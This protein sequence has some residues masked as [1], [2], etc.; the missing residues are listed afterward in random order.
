MTELRLGTCEMVAA[1]LGAQNP[2][3]P[4]H[5]YRTVSI[6]EAAEA[7]S[8]APSYPDR[9]YEDSILP[10]RLQDAYNRVKHA[11]K[12]ATAVLEN[13][14]L[15]ATF[16]LERG[17]RLWSL[18]HKPS[19]RELLHVNPVFQPANLA[20]RDAWFSGGV[21]WNLSIIGHCP[22]T[23]SPLFAANVMAEDG[24][25]VLRLYEYERVRRVPFQIDFHLPAGSEFLFARPRIVNTNAHAVPMYWWSNIAVD[26]SPGVRVLAPANAAYFH[27]Y[28]RRL[29][30]QDLPMRGREDVTYPGR[31]SAAADLY[32][33]IPPQRWPWVAALDAAGRGMVHAST[34]R[35]MGRKMFLWGMGPGGRRWQE[36]LAAPG[37]Q[38]IEIQGGLA[39]T[40]TEYV[41]MPAGACWEWV[42]AFGS[43]DADPKSVHSA[44]WASA[45]EHVD[46]KLES[47]LPRNELEARLQHW[48]AD[49]DRAPVE[50]LQEGS[51]WGALEDRRRRKAGL[52]AMGSAATP[53][54][55]STLG[56]EQEPWRRLLD[57]GAFPYR[58]PSQ[59]PGAYL[60]D[61]AW[62]D[63]LEHAIAAGRGVHWLSLLHAGI[64]RYRA[65]DRAGAREAWERSLAAEP[66]AWAQ[67]NVA[68]ISLDEGNKARA[69]ELLA[70]AARMRPGLTPLAIE[71]CQTMLAAG[72]YSQLRRLIG[73]L[74]DEVATTGRVRLIGTI[75]ALRSGDLEAPA[76]FFS[77]PCD[78]PN[79]RE[80][81]ISLSELW[82]EWHEAR[83]SR[84][85]DVPIDD[86]L[87]RQVRREHPLPRKFDFRM[88][89]D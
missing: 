65:G 41:T 75:A 4:L 38:Y 60:T 59:S 50:I 36:Y 12:F 7:S 22:F 89:A 35:L 26:E 46:A 1:E 80:G 57:E 56:D 34:Q 81:E 49:A 79:I 28:D 27:D 2:L 39:T 76:A 44:D 29:K 43:F 18:F 58:E 66:S 54:A 52:V 8:A 48:H 62:R 21:E 70:V 68:I 63:L 19:Q 32:F 64:M 25:P 53:F 30:S 37:H 3:P 5:A 69:A 11:R 84:Q 33:R 10:Y 85:Q 31:R 72:Q 9:G 16:L 86:A 73:R 74:P 6:T 88:K 47:V 71:A 51:G 82:F 83:L 14:F 42:E 23:C 15:R 13:E 67:R 20:V 78:I 45:I 40:Q 24:T 17:G 55:G 77:A 87:R 61:P